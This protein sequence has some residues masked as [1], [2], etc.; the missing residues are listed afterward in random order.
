MLMR[1]LRTVSAA[2]VGSAIALAM[3]FAA[4]AT[5]VGTDISTAGLTASGDV[6]FSD[7]D[8]D[9]LDLGDANDTVT[10]LGDVAITDSQWSV[11]AAGVG[12]F[13]SLSAG[14]SSIT[15]TKVGNWDTAYGWGNHASAGYAAN[16]SI[17]N[18][19]NWDTA[20]G[21]GNHA[22][23]GYLTSFTELDPVFGAHA[24]ANVTSGKITNWDT[25]Y[26]WGNHASAGYLTSY[27]ES[28]PL[29]FGSPASTVTGTQITNWDT[30]YGWGNH[31]S[32][33]YLTSFTELDPVFGAHA[34]ANVT[35]GKITNWDTAYGWGDHSAAGYLDSTNNLSDV[36][37]APLA[38]NALLPSQ[39]GQSGNF[40][41]TNGSGT[42]TW[43]AVSGASAGA[44]SDIT[45]M[46]GLTGLVNGLDNQNPGTILRLRGGIPSGPTPGY[47]MID[48]PGLTNT[49][50]HSSM[51]PGSLFI[52]GGLEVDGLTFIDSST[53]I[54]SDVASAPAL[55]TRAASGQTA[56]IQEWTDNSN[57]VL[58]EVDRNG[59]GKFNNAYAEI[60]NFY[61]NASVTATNANTDYKFPFL[62]DGLDTGS[63]YAD[64]D[65]ANDKI[66]I[67]AD[68]AGTYLVNLSGSFQSSV[69]GATIHARVYKNGSNLQKI[70]FDRRMGTAGDEGGGAAS[71]LVTLASGDYL[72]VYIRSS[73]GS[74]TISATHLDLVATRISN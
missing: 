62:N 12:S 13:A 20:Y 72:E 64:A 30:A 54:E 23:A 45:S 32:A 8:A 42:V 55:N 9:T 4:L 63:N 7:S 65:S 61:G 40:L 67:G 29:F 56:A 28:D 11:T 69:N 74:N 15:S 59:Y 5:T 36:A 66:V 10:I 34:A 48:H 26:G 73:A 35:S 50:G 22:S 27:M 53:E 52:E 19:A 24:A 16:A 6:D 25:A 38:L 18:A 17:A 3:P 47:V 57:S 58:A 21:W 1:K 70:E 33:G 71:G 2:L 60:Y 37:S 39:S 68:G 43:A 51:D 44:N 49:P 41:T 14:G 46:S 31:A